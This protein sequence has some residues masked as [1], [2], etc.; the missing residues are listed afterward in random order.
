MGTITVNQISTRAWNVLNDPAATRWPLAEFIDWTND[1]SREIALAQPESSTV[2]ANLALVAGTKQTLP[3]RSIM[4]ARLIRN[5]GVSGT[6]PGEAPRQASMETMDLHAP[7]W[8]ADTASLAVKNWF[9][10]ARTP[11]IYYV[12]PPMASVTF[13][14]AEYSTTP[15]LLTAGTDTI[16]L[17][18]I[19]VNP[20]VDYVLWRAFSK[21]IEI[22]GMKSKA[23][24]HRS[25]FDAAL[26]LTKAGEEDTK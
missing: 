17:D 3:A 16:N 10:D 19:Y 9:K 26:S 1:A 18:D 7:T 22:P 5:M 6:A 13:V 12:W 14:E 15:V 4:L 8:H 25:A 23:D 21:D 2:I 11:R 20:I 24:K